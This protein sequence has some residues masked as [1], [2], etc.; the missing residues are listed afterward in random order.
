M[1]DNTD[2]DDNSAAINPNA[3]EVCDG[4]DNDCD[5]DI[6]DA[7]SSVS[8]QSTFFV[9]SDLDGFAGSSTV[10]ACNQP[11]N[12]FLTSDDCDD[13]NAANNPNASEVCDGEDNDCITK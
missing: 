13:S 11:A 8:G 5:N 6:D 12:T 4:V 1:A 10:D 2:C 7:D 9:D 3:S